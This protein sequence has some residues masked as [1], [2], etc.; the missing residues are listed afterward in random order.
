[1]SKNV[2][3][4]LEGDFFCD[5]SETFAFSISVSGATTVTSPACVLY[6]GTQD[7]SST[8]LSG[9]A[10]VTGTTITTKT[11]SPSVADEYMLKTTATVDGFTRTFLTKIISLN[12]W[13]QL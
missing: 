2:L 12:P 10:S 6:K 4:P 13:E 3:F 9:S 11:V 7:V 5:I 1:M 8:Y